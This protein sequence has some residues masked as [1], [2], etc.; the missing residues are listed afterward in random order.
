MLFCREELISLASGEHQTPFLENLDVRRLNKG[1]IVVD[2][3]GII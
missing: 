3:W 1:K 2:F